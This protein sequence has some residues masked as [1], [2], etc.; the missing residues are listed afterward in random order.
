[1]QETLIGSKIN[2]LIINLAEDG[3]CFPI[4][5]PIQYMP[6]QIYRNHSASLYFLPLHWKNVKQI[7]S[8]LFAYIMK[9]MIDKNIVK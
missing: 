5:C 9:S 2:Q 7:L 1:M 6:N 8:P 3:E 4:L